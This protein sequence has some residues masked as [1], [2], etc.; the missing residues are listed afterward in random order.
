MHQLVIHQWDNQTNLIDNA[1]FAHQSDNQCGPR[2]LHRISA[3][4]F[5]KLG[6]K[7]NQYKIL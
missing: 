7:L 1:A 5:R 3:S 4:E 6:S 2:I